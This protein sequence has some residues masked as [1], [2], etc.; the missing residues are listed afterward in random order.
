MA[1][2]VIRLSD[3]VEADEVDLS[4]EFDPPLERGQELTGAQAAAVNM[5]E[6][7]ADA[8]KDGSTSVEGS[9]DA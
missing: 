8:I 2:V 7:V 5:L 1:S 6:S 3:D 4:V 9:A